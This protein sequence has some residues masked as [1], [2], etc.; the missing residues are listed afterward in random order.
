[1][2]VKEWLNRGYRIDREITALLRE[3]E[4]TLVLATKT[5][6]ATDGERVQTSRGNSAEARFINYADY[7]KLIDERIDE[8]YAIK[9]E[10]IT[11]INRVG[12]N[13][14]RQLLI[15]RYIEFM[16][17]EKI[18]EEMH[19]SYVHV[20]HTLHPRALAAISETVNRI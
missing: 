13:T 1:M 20:V 14:L 3:Q 7:T 15:H 6:A 12:D 17:W 10:I 9:R 2:T 18:A 4:R 16:R 8:L 19:Y 11:A 5:T